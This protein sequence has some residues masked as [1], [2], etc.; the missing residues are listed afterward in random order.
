AGQTLQVAEFLP[1]GVRVLQDLTD[2]DR[3]GFSNILAGGDCA[4]WDRAINPDATEVFGNDVDEDCDGVTPQLESSDSGRGRLLYGKVPPEQ[5]R[6][7]NIVWIVV[8]ALRADS[9][10]FTDY[11][12]KPKSKGRSA[13][14]YL[15]ELAKESWVFHNAYAQ[16][17]MTMLSMPSM[18]AGRWPAKMSWRSHTDRPNA[19]D[20]ELLIAEQ[21]RAE[22]YRT[23]HVA[24]GYLVK[25]LPGQFQ[26]QQEVM[27][28]WFRGKRSPWFKLASRVAVS[29]GI[30]FLHQDPDFP[31]SETPFFLTLYTDGPH[32]PYITHPDSGVVVGKSPRSRYKG[33]I[34]DTDHWL[35]A[36]L[37]Y[38][39]Y[40]DEGSV[41]ENTI[42][43]VSADHGEEFKEHGHTYHAR[44]CHEE[45]VHVPLMIR[46]PGMEPAQIDTRVA[47]V[48]VVPTLLDMLGLEPPRDD[49]DGQSLAIPA[50]EPEAVDPD[51]SIFCTTTAIRASF[52]EFFRRSVRK[53]DWVLMTDPPNNNE[54][55]FDTTKDRREHN[56]LL[57]GAEGEAGVAALREELSRT[58]TGNIAKL[59]FF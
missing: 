23:G 32:N 11:P 4:P 15:D 14:P 19:V 29:L 24:S 37:E 57:P 2:I 12:G 5:I 43:I 38:L 48:D 18:F 39:R 40:Q 21:L 3:D 28:Y 58:L 50:L 33:E 49:L 59:K 31:R 42:V 22:G 20:E 26:G 47:L 1:T 51:R 6:R 44:T 36:F 30:D 45:S 35:K 55:L 10:G 41:W 52:G 46:I 13:T 53:G 16:S 9:V 56:N 25:R 27:N 7:Y 34:A 17:S 54:L 8:D